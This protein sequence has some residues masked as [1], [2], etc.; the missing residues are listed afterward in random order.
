MANIQLAEW[1][2]TYDGALN[3]AQNTMRSIN[4]RIAG[5][6]S[7]ASRAQF[8]QSHSR[9]IQNSKNLESTISKLK[10]DLDTLT[11]NRVISM[12]DM[13]TKD[14][15]IQKIVKL[16]NEIK[17]KLNMTEAEIMNEGRTELLSGANKVDQGENEETRTL[18]NN[19]MLQT[20]EQQVDRIFM[21]IL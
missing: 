5:L 4:E 11:K 16:H 2:S 10:S 18:S 20:F 19:E 14:Q 9:N 7:G 6:K 17:T 8:V 15:K 12:Q 3:L 21:R 1:N 13:Q